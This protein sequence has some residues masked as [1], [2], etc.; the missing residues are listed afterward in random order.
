MERIK[1]IKE[2]LRQLE[3]QAAFLRGQLAILEEPKSDKNDPS[4][5]ES[6]SVQKEQS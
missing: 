4:D 1:K 3:L 2:T 5:T 6:E